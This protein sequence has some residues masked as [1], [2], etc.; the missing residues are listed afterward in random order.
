MDGNY[1]Y[2]VIIYACLVALDD[3][4]RRHL[5]AHVLRTT[6]CN[7]DV[8]RRVARRRCCCFPRGTNERFS[9]AIAGAVK[10]NRIIVEKKKKT[11]VH[12]IR[13]KLP[14]IVSK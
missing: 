10:M 8:Y 1:L 13:K 2:I 6:N 9:G 5:R 11:I 3:R 7:Y 12:I 14:T 4:P